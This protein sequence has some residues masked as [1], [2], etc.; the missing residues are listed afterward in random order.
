[1]KNFFDAIGMASMEKI[2]SAVIGWMLSDECEALTISERSE[3][4]YTLFGCG[5]EEKT[6]IKTIRA[7]VEVNNIDI[8]FITN[9]GDKDQ[10]C[11]V[12]ENKIKSNQHSDQLDKY[13]NIVK[14]NEFTNNRGIK[15]KIETYKNFTPSFCF[16]TLVKEEPKVNLR[17]FGKTLYIATYIEPWK[18]LWEKQL[19]NHRTIIFSKN[20]WNV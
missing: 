19:K 12:I 4:L 20:T 16:L 9:E 7:E 6:P 3:L 15:K 11:W 1:M 5:N 18:E 8:L 13:Y 17:V 10:A 2:H 14:G